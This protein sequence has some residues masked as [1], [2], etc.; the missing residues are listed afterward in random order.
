MVED[1]RDGLRS[2]SIVI[3][4]SRENDLFYFIKG[5]VKFKCIRNTTSVVARELRALLGAGCERLLP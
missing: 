5:L 3:R 2:A 4:L 1:G